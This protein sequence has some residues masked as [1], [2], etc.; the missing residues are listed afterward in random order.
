MKFG[1][2]PVAEAAGA[3]LAHS[4]R[5]PG[6]RIGKGMVLNAG[7]VAAMQEAGLSEVTVARLEGGDLH[8][9]AAAT[10]LAAAVLARD[11]A[12][13]ELDAASTGRVNIRATAPGVVLLD[14]AAIHGANA[15]NPMITIATVPP[16]HRMA[17]RGLVATIKII[18][19]GVPAADV[20]AA[21][22]RADGAIGF[23][24]PIYSTATLI[25]TRTGPVPGDKGRRA[26][27][28]RL[29]RL[30]IALDSRVVVPHTED[31]VAK[32]LTAASGQIVFI[33]TASAT[34]DIRD[35]AP[36]G[37]RRAGGVVTQFGMPVDPGNLL[38]IGELG[39]RPVIGLPGCARSPARNG[40]D[41]V[42]ERV[43]CG[44]PVTPAD[45]ARMGVGGLLKEIPSRPRPRETP[46][47]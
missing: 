21:A 45:I 38:F 41:S 25:E 18:A 39:A 37:V 43:A 19:Y 35:T 44:V 26:L 33:L 40:A 11:A 9:D 46:R 16:F 8:E 17:A 12:G 23:A 7:H 14:T 34:S 47:G 36:E 2:I 13:L 32:A 27:K 31:A 28:T 15:L 20:E 3:I 5:L 22:R 10:R 42:L 1:P 24:T 4:M 29:D 30:G 6:G